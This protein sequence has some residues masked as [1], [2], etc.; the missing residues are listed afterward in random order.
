MTRRK[1]KYTLA[2]IRELN[3]KFAPCPFCGERPR[4]VFSDDEGN[5]K[6][7]DDE[8]Y[9]Q[10]PWSGLSFRI[11]HPAREC[12]VATDDRDYHESTYNWVYNSPEEAVEDWNNALKEHGGSN[13]A[14]K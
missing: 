10:D 14:E 6:D 2:D 12:P 8:E 9:L 5:W 1:R 11:A 13:N 3:G 4:I 7:Q